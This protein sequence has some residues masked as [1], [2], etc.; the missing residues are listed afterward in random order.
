MIQ[1]SSTRTRL[2]SLI[3]AHDA[4]WLAKAKKRTASLIKKQRYDE[5]SAIWSQVK[6]VYIVLQENKC[7]F[8]ERQLES[9]QY[10][11]IEFDLEHFR[12]KS[13]VQ[14]WPAES[15]RTKYDFPTGG[16]A[17]SGYY[18]LA[19]EIDNYAA[20]CKVCNSPLK[21]NYFPIAGRRGAVSDAPAQLLYEKPFLCYPLCD[22]DDDPESLITFVATTAV[23]VA[24]G[25]HKRRRAIV[26]IDFFQ[27]NQREQLHKERARLIAILGSSLRAIADGTG[28]GTDMSIAKRMNSKAMPHAACLR[29]FSNIWDGDRRLAN[30][31]LDA[32][33]AYVAGETNS[34]P[35]P[36]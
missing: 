35:Q 29:A 2:T 13:S 21:S 34:V 15:D 5:S 16:A 20:S 6:P 26:T 18:W 33:R 11:T 8:C 12:P 7:I 9:A 24:K 32:C 30:R 23:P 25:G 17:P 31:Y 27:L 1:Y 4:K 22:F 36:N 10:G 28:D 14:A 3:D 19:Y